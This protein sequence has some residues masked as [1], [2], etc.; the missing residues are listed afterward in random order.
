MSVKAGSYM[1]NEEK[2]VLQ[3]VYKAK[4]INYAQGEWML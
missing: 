1:Q 4:P 3:P 2:Y